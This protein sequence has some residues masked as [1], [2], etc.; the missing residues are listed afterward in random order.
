MHMYICATL[1]CMCHVASAIYLPKRTDGDMP[2]TVQ[3][4]WG[5]PVCFQCHS[6]VSLE[7]FGR[8]SARSSSWT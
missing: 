5:G 8:L 7:F 6:T 4:V 1:C 3:H 2:Q